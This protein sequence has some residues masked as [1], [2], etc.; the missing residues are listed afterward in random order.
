[1]RINHNIAAMNTYRQLN[2][3][4]DHTAKSL[5]K[6][7]SGL[8]I[9]RAGDDAAGL[10]ISEKMRAQIRGLDQ[11]SRNASDSI[12]L[13]QTAEGALNE[14]QDILQRMRELS[15][16]SANDT[17]VSID[18]TS[19]QQEL[20][21][22]TSEINR[23]GNTTEFNTQALLNGD[24]L[25]NYTLTVTGTAISGLASGVSAVVASGTLSLV[26]GATALA[27][28]SYSL[29]VTKTVDSGTAVLK[30]SGVNNAGGTLAAATSDVNYLGTKPTFSG[31]INVV[32]TTAASGGLMTAAGGSGSFAIYNSGGLVIVSGT[33]NSGVSFTDTVS[34][35]A[36]G[37]YNYDDHGVSF[38]ITSVSGWASGTAD[39]V[40]FDKAAGVAIANLGT[41][42]TLWSSVSLGTAVTSS[43]FN[44]AIVGG[45]IAIAS[46]QTGGITSGTFRVTMADT[47]TNLSSGTITVS[48]NGPS[49]AFSDTFTNLVDATN[50]TYADH[51]ITMT[52]DLTKLGSGGSGTFAFDVNNEVKASIYQTT[53]HAALLD[54]SGN[55][56]DSGTIGSSAFDSGASAMSGIGMAIS[57]AS[58]VVLASGAKVSYTAA[59]LTVGSGTFSVNTTMASGGADKS[60]KF[61]IGANAN[62]SM[63][64]SINDMRASALGL[65]SAAGTSG[66]TSANSVTDGRTDNA[67]EAALDVSTVSGATNA[68]TVINTAINSVSTERAKLGA[69]QNRLEH[70]INNLGTSSENLTSAESRI[71]D[72]DMAK[73]MMEFTKNNILS[74]AA[75]SMLAQANQ[76]PQGVLQLLR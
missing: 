42:Q 71:R 28:G 47:S 24:K 52:L 67:T 43:T 18:R 17:N 15:V 62:Q 69:S 49:G 45:S 38:D 66:F 19:I 54:N 59:A 8:R 22:L 55:A 50:F 73:E 60:L 37:K 53:Y 33:N 12:S 64:L 51:G 26:S 6:L 21:Q 10:A 63:A 44:T 1:M 46:G 30:A 56:L 11:A 76:Q 57:S 9:N 75:Q 13:I 72:V 39:A 41:S 23:I 16:Q 2:M 27:T 40:K 14:T 74:Q 34:A 4:T 25:N 32:A 48:G 29:Q 31:D 58:T 3:N 65:T 36:S 61:Q 68:I 20:T 7:S 35:D 70:T 5:E